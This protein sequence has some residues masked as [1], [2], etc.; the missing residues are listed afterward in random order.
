MTP[1]RFQTAQKNSAS[2]RSS[3][4]QFENSSDVIPCSVTEQCTHSYVLT[5][6]LQMECLI[7]QSL[8]S[9]QST[10]LFRTMDDYAKRGG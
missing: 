4:R 1:F 7:G 6:Y 8:F 2:L 5:V 3:V 10:F 9:V